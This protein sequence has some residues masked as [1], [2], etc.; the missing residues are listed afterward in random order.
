MQEISR[1][2]YF[3]YYPLTGRKIIMARKPEFEIS[4]G[5]LQKYNGSGGKVVIPDSVRIIG[6]DAFSNCQKLT[7]VVIP[8]SVQQIWARAAIPSWPKW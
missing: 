4:N 3:K 6:A 1:N 8:N 2:F 7:A 5:I